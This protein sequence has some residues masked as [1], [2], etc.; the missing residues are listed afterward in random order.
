MSCPLSIS[1]LPD[2]ETGLQSNYGAKEKPI[3]GYIGT[4]APWVDMRLINTMARSLPNYEFVIIGPLLKQ[5]GLALL[6]KNMYY[7]GHRHYSV[8]P[9]Y[10]SNF[11]YCLIPFKMTEM[12]KGVNPIKL[13]EYLASGIPILSTPIP[14][15]PWN[16]LP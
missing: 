9:Q 16:T 2:F 13:W 8:L 3:I 7:L 14:E 6:N 5:P 11:S 15:V 10:L 12:T 1:I 4:I